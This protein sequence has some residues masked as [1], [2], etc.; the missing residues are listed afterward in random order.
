MWLL[1]VWLRRL[2]LRVPCRK[3]PVSRKIPFCRYTPITTSLRQLIFQRPHYV[4]GFYCLRIYL[5]AP[6]LTIPWPTERVD[7]LFFL[8]KQQ[9]LPDYFAYRHTF[10]GLAYSSSF[11]RGAGWSKRLNATQKQ[12]KRFRTIDWHTPRIALELYCILSPILFPALSR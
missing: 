8:Y 5:G 10:K 3:F 6:L 7:Q 2:W 11:V 9:Y 1:N 12:T 4:N